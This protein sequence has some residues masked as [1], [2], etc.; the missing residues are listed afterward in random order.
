MRD[1]YR[2]RAPL[3]ARERLCAYGEDE[4]RE[5]NPIVEVIREMI[6]KQSLG[7]SMI[8]VMKVDL[9]AGASKV[10]PELACPAHNLEEAN[11]FDHGSLRRVTSPSMPGIACPD[12]SSPLVA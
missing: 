5:A 3:I 4:N 12:M 1:R 7:W 6:D 10:N 2:H 11:D 9:R 8:L